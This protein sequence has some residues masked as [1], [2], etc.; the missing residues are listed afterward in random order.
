MAVAYGTNGDVPV[1]G[2]F[3]GDGRADYAIFRPSTGAWYVRPSSGAPDLPS[4][5]WGTAGDVALGA[6]MS[7]DV[8]ADKVIWRPSSG[9]WYVESAEGTF[10]APVQWGAPG[11]IAIAQ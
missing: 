4:V 11:D 6:Q 9:I 7:G 10:P 8:R 3:T 2:D 5:N 1:A